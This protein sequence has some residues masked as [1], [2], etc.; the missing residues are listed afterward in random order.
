MSS[1]S[2]SSAAPRPPKL[3]LHFDVNETI[4]V[5]DPA[6]GDTFEQSLNK[7]ICKTA[8]VQKRSIGHDSGLPTRWRDGSAISPATPPPPLFTGF[9][10]P[11]D[12]VSFYRAGRSAKA[13]AQTFTEPGQ[14]GE[15][16]RPLYDT[17]E[18]A[19]R[20]PAS[21]SAAAAAVPPPKRLCHD[22]VHHFLIPAFFTTICELAKRGRIFG[23]VVRTFGTDAHDVVAALQ[24]YAEGLHLPVF[25]D[26]VVSEMSGA[27]LSCWKGSYTQEGAFYLERAS[28]NGQPEI[29]RDEDEIVRI[30]H[31]QPDQISCVVCTDDYRWWK[32]HGFAPSAG[33]PIWLDYTKPQHNFLPIFFDDNIHN[34]AED[35]IVAVRSK[36][37]DGGTT[38]ASRYEAMSGEETLAEQG[39]HLVRVPTVEPIQNPR[40]FLEQIDLCEAAW[41]ARLAEMAEM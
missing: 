8:L 23:I 25:N 15:A 6:G 26:P 29:I 19:L 1:P 41:A 28:S 33:K 9:A 18:A 36:R 4:L 13:C 14:P 7:T 24:A 5:G 31:G 38:V 17:L 12:T 37:G 32:D 16:Y 39:V 22:G 30:L 34:D 11:A 2:S 3:I 20:W 21:S 40:W 10:W 35:A 27:A